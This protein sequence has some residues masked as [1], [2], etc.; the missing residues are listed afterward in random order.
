[1]TDAFRD[2]LACPACGEDD[3]SALA[4]KTEVVLECR[5]C[6]VTS[7]FVFGEDVP[8][9]DVDQDAVEAVAEE[10]DDD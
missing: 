4:Y 6:G 2:W 7:E 3:V 5:D 8:L 9:R 1:M 10:A